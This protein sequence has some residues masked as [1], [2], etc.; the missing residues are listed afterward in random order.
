MRGDD[1]LDAPSVIGAGRKGVG[2][3]IDDE[4][5]VEDR[6]RDAGASNGARRGEVDRADGRT[7]VQGRATHGHTV[8]WPGYGIMGGERSCGEDGAVDRDGRESRVGRGTPR[9]HGGGQRDEQRGE[10]GSGEWVR[11]HPSRRLRRQ[12]TRAAVDRRA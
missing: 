2:E 7:L 5:R 12:D 11:D 9:E 6:R 3:W 1:V 8:G 10:R 4:P